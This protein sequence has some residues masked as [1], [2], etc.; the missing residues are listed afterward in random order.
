MNPAFVVAAV[1][2]YYEIAEKEV[3]GGNRSRICTLA[4]RITCALSTEYTLFSHVDIGHVLG[5]DHTT[6]LHACAR[7]REETD[8]RYLRDVAAIRARLEQP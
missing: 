3:R 4:R 5:I 7:H 6:V 2:R 8:A 1:C